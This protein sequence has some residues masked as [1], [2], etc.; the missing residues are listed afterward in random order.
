MSKVIDIFLQPGEYFVGDAD[1]RIRTLL[2]SCVSITLWHPARRIG[3]MSHFLLSRRGP[4]TVPALFAPLAPHLPHP[5]EVM[6]ARYGEEAMDL[7]LAELRRARVAPDECQG[8]IFG[9]GNMFPQLQRN[10]VMNVGHRNGE[11]ARGLL[12]AHGIRIVSESLFGDGHRQIIFDV[13]S[14]D[15]WAR[16][17]RPPGTAYTRESA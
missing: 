8:K 9:G 11:A 10:E 3:A 14:G 13:R 6:D 2:G 17:V 12:H 16:Q 7:M 1:Y 5:L 15:V 4:A